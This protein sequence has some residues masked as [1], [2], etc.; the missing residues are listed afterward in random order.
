MNRRNFFTKLLTGA[1]VIAVAPQILT[2]RKPY[3]KP[4]VIGPTEILSLQKDL[5]KAIVEMP[6]SPYGGWYSQQ[7][8]A[9]RLRLQIDTDKILFFGKITP[10]DIHK[11]WRRSGG[12]LCYKV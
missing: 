8:A 1:A 3:V 11:E 9:A 12:I 5:M 10:E 4:V 6:I 2:A 7:E